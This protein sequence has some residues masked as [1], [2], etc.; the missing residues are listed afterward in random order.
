MV[1]YTVKKGDSVYSIAKAYGTTA[2]R[3]IADNDLSDPDA[4][5]VG[6]TLVLTQPMITY[7]VRNG[8][9]A[10]S[11]AQQFG[12]S[13]NRLYRNN[14]SLGGEDSLR[15]GQSL[16][17]V[18]P[19][20]MYDREVEVNGYAYPSIDRAVLR[21]TLP[22]LTYLTIFTYGFREDGTLIETDD[23]ELIE[24][25]RQHGVAPIL[26]LSSLTEE[27]TFSSALAARLLGDQTLQDSIIQAL[28]SVLAQKRYAGVE[29]DFEYIE[30]Q[31]ADRYVAFLER[32]KQALS[33]G[34]YWLFVALAPKTESDQPGL[35]YEGLDYAG[36][37]STADRSLIMT[38]EWG[39]AYGEP[40]A[41]SPM[42]KV[43]QV[44]DY[45]VSVIPAEKIFLGV[46]SYGYDWPLPY[47]A[48]ETEGV[49][50]GNVAAVAL[51]EEKKA[52]ILFDDVSKAPYF[53]YFEREGGRPVEHL[54]Y[55][56]DARSVAAMLALVADKKLAGFSVWNLMRYFPSLWTV[57]GGSFH[58]KKVLD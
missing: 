12:I 35:L 49:S 37:G 15:P 39:Y 10:Y 4:L 25:A 14:P 23:D 51:A 32:M 36:L 28:L 6:Q 20:P 19:H 3:I 52:E 55:F 30:G 45:S 1:I 26:Q 29:V 54:V 7:R 16:S 38:Y 57:L 48:G 56:E 11:V 53:R 8:D 50:L 58:I 33:P 47:V 43:E 18:L 24:L 9:T 46:P 41:V 21:R 5:V 34:G 42:N 31:Y 17:I 44:I 2:E 40:Q 27:G 13:L 22:Y